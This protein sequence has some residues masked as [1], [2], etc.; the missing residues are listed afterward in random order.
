MLVIC[1]KW[2]NYP[3]A[4]VN[5]A[6]GHQETPKPPSGGFFFYGLA[7]LDAISLGSPH[8][9]P[10]FTRTNQ[11]FIPVSVDVVLNDKICLCK[12]FHKVKLYIVLQP[13]I[14]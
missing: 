2:A 3:Q 11:I 14:G 6:S 8:Q 7:S 5:S 13:I 10:S 4:S 9:E 12:Q 1:F